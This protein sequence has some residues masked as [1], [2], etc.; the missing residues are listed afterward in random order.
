MAKLEVNYDNVYCDRCEKYIRP[1]LLRY[2]TDD[3]R[4]L[5]TDCYED[6]GE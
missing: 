4:I 3:D 6:F 2:R 5:C 1:G